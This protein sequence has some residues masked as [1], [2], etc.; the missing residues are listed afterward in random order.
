MVPDGR[1]I[2]SGKRRGMP[3]F[4]YAFGCHGTETYDVPLRAE[5]ERYMIASGLMPTFCLNTM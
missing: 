1:Q 2:L 5:K 4:M 3:V